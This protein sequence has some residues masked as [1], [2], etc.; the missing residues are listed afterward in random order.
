MSNSSSVTKKLFVGLWSLINFTRK[1]FLNIIFFIILFFILVI[2]FSGEDEVLVPLES[3]LVLDPYGE[4]V[5]QKFQADPFSEFVSEA[6]DQPEDNPEVLLNDL[7]FAIENARDDTRIKALVLDFQG[8]SGGLDKLETVA[9]AIEDFKTSG[10]PVYAFGDYYTQAQYYVA[11]HADKVFMHPQG[12]LMFDGY[13]SYGMY[14]RTLLEKVKA[15]THVF[16]VGTYKSYVE[17]Y[18]RDDMSDEARRANE[19]WLTE[20]WDQYK[21]NVADARG[22]DKGVFDEQI[23]VFLSKFEAADG[24]FGQY[25]LQNGWVDALLTRDQIVDLMA[26]TVPREDNRLGYRNLSFNTYIKAIRS[27]LPKQY[28][29][30]QIAV[31]VAK[32]TIMNGY[33]ENGMIGGDST[34]LLLRKARLDDNV[35]A[36]VLQVDS[37]GGSAFASDIIRREVDLIKAAGKPVVVSMSSVAASG[38][39]WISSSADEIWATPSTITGSIGV[40]GMFMTFEK[41]LEHIGVNV[42]GVGTTDFAGLS[43]ARALD[44]RVGQVFQMSVEQTY[45]QF[46]TLVGQDRGMTTEQVDNIAQ[47]R[48]WIGT[49]AQ[50]IGLV[51]KLGYLQDAIASAANLAELDDYKVRYIERELTSG[52]IFMQNLFGSAAGMLAST[53][54][55]ERDSQLLGMIKSLVKEFDAMAQFNDPKGTYIFCL[56]CKVSL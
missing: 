12:V 10:K 54:V 19:A 53:Q 1:L 4:I 41:S 48:V 28:G 26:E 43:V 3:A 34:A 49:T 50:Q 11:A 36:V 56:P 33:Q 38:G 7:L 6:L 14:F 32:G 2:M 37:P 30:K 40:F 51:D 23:E 31:V 5:V 16:R 45:H 8:V 39:Y 44:P 17:P 25:A 13:G 15:S 29:N 52:E 46:I 21:T 18:I 55:D 42:D 20:I 35:K 9:R 24:S 47:G 27:P 22:L